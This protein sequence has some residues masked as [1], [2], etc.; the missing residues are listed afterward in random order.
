MTGLFVSGTDT[1][2]GKT[3]VT[4]ALAAWCRR[5]G[6]NV[7]VMKPVATGGRPLGPAGRRRWISD[8]ALL[9]ASCAGV[10]DPAEDINPVCYREPLAPMTAAEREGRPL[11]LAQAVAAFRR[12]QAKHDV[13]L[14][15]GIGGLLVPLTPRETVA[16]LARALGL[17]VLLV[18]R[19]NLGT[20][21]HTLLS[22][23]ALDR[24]GVPCAGLII[25]AA[26]PSGRER[27]ARLAERTNPAMLSRYANL[28]GQLP[29]DRRLAARLRDARALA[30]WTAQ[31]VDAAWLRSWS[32]PRALRL[33]GS[34]AYGKVTTVCR[35]SRIAA[36]AACHG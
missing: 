33:T 27:M 36:S 21:N 3:V 25:N 30:R 12:L 32:D 29:F 10:D 35:P 1:G 6:L 34:K 8:D 19:P 7:G 18:A 26:A 2:V 5:Q 4:C 14:V 11:R 9:A 20:L 28:V 23:A 22:L 15:E 31:H 16:D 24:A 17:P 13:M